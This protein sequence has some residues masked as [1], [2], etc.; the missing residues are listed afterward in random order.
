MRA[1]SRLLANNLFSNGVSVRD[2]WRYQVAYRF[3][4]ITEKIAPA[5]YG[6]TH[7]MNKPI[8]KLVLAT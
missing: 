1:P 3:S 8:W 2:I 5:A 6:V 4:F 7:N